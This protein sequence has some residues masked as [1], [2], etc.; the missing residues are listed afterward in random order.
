M[1]KL[2]CFDAIEGKNVVVA[3]CEVMPGAHQP[4]YGTGRVVEDIVWVEDYMVSNA[5]SCKGVQFFGR[6]ENDAL[7]MHL[8][9]IALAEDLGGAG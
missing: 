6:D 2:M 7:L 8:A 1:Y 4:L 9:N 3:V 5:E